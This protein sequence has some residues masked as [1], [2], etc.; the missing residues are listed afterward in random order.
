MSDVLENR[1]ALAGEFTF[2]PSRLQSGQREFVVA[3]TGHRDLV[4][5]QQVQMALSGAF[6]RIAAKHPSLR[7]V[8][9][10]ALAEGA[11]RVALQAFQE[12]SRTSGHPVEVRA[13]LPMPP[14]IYIST[15]EDRVAATAEFNE[16]LSELNSGPVVLNRSIPSDVPKEEN[17]LKQWQEDCFA[18]LADYF[19][20]ST[21]AVI[22]VWD[23]VWVTKT[24]GT[25]YLVENLK[26]INDQP[27]RCRRIWWLAV[28]RKSNPHPSNDAFTWSP[29]SLGESA[30][31]NWFTCLPTVRFLAAKWKSI[32]L[33][34]LLASTV[35]FGYLGFRTDDDGSRLDAFL[36]AASH[37]AF[38]GFGPPEP[39]PEES[40]W[41][42][43]ISR[44]SAVL[45]AV[46]G[47]G[48]LLETLFQFFSRYRLWRVAGKP[49]DLIIGLGTR[50]LVLLADADRKRI[51]SLV[52]EARPDLNAREICRKAGAALL[53][54]DAT[55]PAVIARIGLPQARHAFVCLGTDEA[56]MKSVYQLAAKRKSGH[57]TSPLVCA[58]GLY[59]RESFQTLQNCLP[60]GHDLD[61]RIFNAE[62]LTARA[63]LRANHLDRF[64][65][66]TNATHSR[67]IL[68]GNG[69]MAE[70]FL[71]QIL[72]Q[73]IFESKRDFRITCLCSD[74]EGSCRDFAD[75]FPCFET[76]AVRGGVWEAAPCATWRTERVLPILDFHE[77]P[78]SDINAI[79][80]FERHL[81]PTK[82][83]T[84]VIVT[85]RNP[86]AAASFSSVII[87]VLE[88][89]RVGGS[90]DIALWTH[91][92]TEDDAMRDDLEQTLNNAS[93]LLPVRVFANFMGRCDRDTAIGA[94][95]DT[96][97][98]R[99]HGLYSHA[100]LDDSALLDSLWRQLTEYDKD[101]NRQAAAHVWVKLRIRA[102]MLRAGADEIEI[103]REL[104]RCEHRRWCAE[105]LLKGFRPLVRIPSEHK[106]FALTAE[107][108]DKVERWFRPD[109]AFKTDCK[110][111]KRHADLLPFDE[112]PLALGP[113]IGAR[114][115]AKDY[116][117]INNLDR[118]VGNSFMF[119]LSR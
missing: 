85:V 45:F 35:I 113:E 95:A 33:G 98:R 111:V 88:Q 71:R 74:A 52:V 86:S 5:S 81:Q 3:V 101:S 13:V 54:G 57:K 63:F 47:A 119:P 53:E 22:A 28:P 40:A 105:Y 23:G 89:V 78:V 49:H 51:P 25:S 30:S 65:A 107:E 61:L 43:R 83:V 29:I 68:V 11:D 18:S 115:Q 73:G 20:T 44:I 75:R 37:F 102:R 38:E 9:L 1:S 6:A 14:E 2:D 24:G 108:S 76:R 110:E 17:K 91:F 104:A 67:V 32:S 31:T 8:L 84:T 112:L 90:S 46:L 64:A 93:P 62:E 19:T 69:P 82:A 79:R 58:V 4:D 48:V 117:Q 94:E 103:A 97:A 15:F 56:N 16:I 116:E 99:I 26:K 72:Q 92:D 66:S 7:I 10:T 34:L 39:L 87:P 21:D 100:D 70:A 27:H 114:E 109:R 12:W 59:H 77:H 55:S 50:G 106:P 42:I 60:K 96:V 80:W 118:L 36:A 41:F